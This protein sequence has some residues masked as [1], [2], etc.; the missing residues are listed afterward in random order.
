[1]KVVSSADLKVALRVLSWAALRAVSSADLKV[2]LRVLSWAALKVVSW[3]DRTDVHSVES[4]VDLTAVCLDVKRV[5]STADNSAA[6]WDVSTAGKRA[7]TWA[8]SA[9]RWVLLWER[10]L[11][12]V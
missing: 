5:A 12:L 9:S 4:W 7:E 6:W 8:K 2:A 3:V 11:Q 1:M 10:S